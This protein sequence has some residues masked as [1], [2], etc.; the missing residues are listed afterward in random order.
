MISKFHDGRR[1][2]FAMN[3][4]RMF[5]AALF[6]LSLMLTASVAQATTV[7]ECQTAIANLKTET[8][9]IAITGR[10]ADK[11][12]AGLIGKL[13]AAAFSLDQA[14]FCDAIQKLNDYRAKVNQLIA[15]GKINTDPM[16]SPTAQ[17]LLTGADNAIACINQLIAQSGV[18]CR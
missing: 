9:S 2:T 11:D 13:D 15:A 17:D 6:A 16:S 10:N 14:K 18:T 1:T 7:S 4:A 12:R 8:T 3:F 5:A